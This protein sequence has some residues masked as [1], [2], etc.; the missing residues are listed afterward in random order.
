MCCWRYQNVPDV[1]WDVFCDATAC[2]Y[3]KMRNK[4]TIFSCNIPTTVKLNCPNFGISVKQNILLCFRACSK[5]IWLR[6]ASLKLTWQLKER[7]EDFTLN[8]PGALPHAALPQTLIHGLSCDDVA[9]RV[10]RSFPLHHGRACDC[11][12]KAQEGQGEA[13]KLNSRVWHFLTFRRMKQMLWSRERKFLKIGT[14]LDVLSLWITE[15][16]EKNNRYAAVHS[17]GKNLEEKG[18]SRT[19]TAFHPV[20]KKNGDT[21]WTWASTAMKGIA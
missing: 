9:P 21:M 13:K 4:S 18:G 19:L 3:S 6:R 1:Q 7:V 5:A 2:M 12:N 16:K 14:W 15:R 10:R 20:K 17:L 11:P 8:L